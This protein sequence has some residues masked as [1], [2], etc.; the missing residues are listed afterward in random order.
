MVAGF[1][2]TFALGQNK[3]NISTVGT[4]VEADTIDVCGTGG[5][6]RGQAELATIAT[7]IVAID[8][9]QIS[10]HQ[11]KQRYIGI[12]VCQAGNGI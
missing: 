5:Q 4:G 11:L 10:I 1:V 9:H 2:F 7:I 3:G 8:F 6:I 12:S